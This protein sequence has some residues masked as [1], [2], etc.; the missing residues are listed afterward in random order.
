MI[1]EICFKGC[2]ALR[3]ENDKLRVII[4][5]SIGGKIAS[6]YRKDKDFEL[7]FQNKENTYRKAK[8]YDSFEL[9]DASGFDDAFPSIDTCKVNYNGKEIIYPDHGEIWSASFNYE[10]H[11][12]RIVLTY[13]SVILKYHYKKVVYIKDS[14]VINEYEII[15]YGNEEFPCI[16]AMHCLVRCEEDM[17]VIL[18][19]NAN[20]VLNVCESKYLGKVGQIHS[21][22]ETIDVNGEPFRLDRVLSPASNNYNKYYINGEV[23]EGFCGIYYPSKNIYYNVY[24][25]K[26]KLPYLGFW[27]TEGGFRGDY[28]CALEPTNGFYDSIAIAQKE[29]KLCVLKGGEKLQF[30]INIEVK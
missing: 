12:E 3:L 27:V 9:F 14:A 17:Q 26:V 18:S 23:E 28:N 15:N 2:R 16:W 8:I 4:L 5:P 7:L 25:D 19:K 22:P 30:D 1:S 20:K 21:Y 10:I 11:D 24:F 13:D 6:I 29:G